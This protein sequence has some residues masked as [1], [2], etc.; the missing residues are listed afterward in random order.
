MRLYAVRFVG[1]GFGFLSELNVLFNI[2]I[3]SIL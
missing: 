3:Y 1:A 2:R